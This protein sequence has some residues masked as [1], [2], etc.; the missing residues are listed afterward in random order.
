MLT[1]T[2]LRYALLHYYKRLIEWLMPSNFCL[3]DDDDNKV[4]MMG[5]FV[6]AEHA[7]QQFFGGSLRILR[8]N[9]LPPDCDLT[10]I[11]PF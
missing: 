10:E 7:Q 5:T 1:P 6:E 3:V 8:Y 9:Q 11:Q 4:L 2:T